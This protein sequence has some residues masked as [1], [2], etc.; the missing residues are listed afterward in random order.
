MSRLPNPSQGN[1]HCP[2]CIERNDMGVFLEYGVGKLF[3]ICFGC[4]RKHCTSAKPGLGQTVGYMP[5]QFS[6][7]CTCPSNDET[8]Q[9]YECDDDVESMKW[10]DHVRL[11]L[12]GV[13]YLMLCFIKT[14]KAGIELVSIATVGVAC[15]IINYIPG[16]PAAAVVFEITT[17]FTKKL[18]RNVKEYFTSFNPRI[19]LMTPQALMKQVVIESIFLLILLISIEATLIS[20]LIRILLIGVHYAFNALTYR[21]S[22]RFIHF[23]SVSILMTNLV[24]VNSVGNPNV[25]R[26]EDVLPGVKKWNGK[27]FYDFRIVWWPT[28]ITAL[29]S[30]A[31]EGWTLLQVARS[32][33]PGAP[34][35]GGN[36]AQ[37]VQ[38]VNRNL[39]LF[40]ALLNYIDRKSWLHQFCVTQMPNDGRGVFNYIWVFGHLQ[41]TSMKTIKLNDEWMHMSMATNGK[42]DKES[43]VDWAEKVDIKGARIGKTNAERRT[44]F[45]EGIPESFAAVIAFERMLPVGNY[46]YPANYVAHDPRAGQPHPHAGEPDVVSAAYAFRPEWERMIKHGLIKKAP[47]GL[48]QEIDDSLSEG[49]SDNDQS[50]NESADESANMAR[51]A[52]TKRTVCLVCGGLGHAADVDGKIKCPNT[53]LKTNVER[54]VLEQIKYPDGITRPSFNNKKSSN[55]KPKHKAHASNDDNESSSSDDNEANFTRKGKHDK[56]KFNKKKS[57]FTPKGK[58]KKAKE[59]EP[60]PE[61]ESSESDDDDD[62][63]EG[64]SAMMVNDDSSSDESVIEKL[65]R[66]VKSLKKAQ[67]MRDRQT[68][69]AVSFDDVEI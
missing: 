36:A 16:M 12:A 63:H 32:Q 58:S 54:S 69:L 49:E 51:S 21:K 55:S 3:T 43:L 6:M 13:H 7:D 29:A 46:V 19:T 57:K 33:D 64:G 4:N 68:E 38:S 40:G 67:Q 45:Y 66:K 11:F 31:Q 30:I 53:I 10:F 37:V 65:K 47:K 50:D 52:I 14:A 59:V 1:Q 22:L 60:E 61:P 9:C 20:F 23:V 56:K 41:L 2:L 42:F 35:N 62:E 34:G 25:E 48:V 26:F 8:L 39:R 27:A 44:K 17:P 5:C 15:A 24:A 28:L 18:V